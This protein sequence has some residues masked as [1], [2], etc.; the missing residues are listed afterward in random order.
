MNQQNTANRRKN[1]DGNANKQTAQILQK[2][3]EIY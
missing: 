1:A 2:E 3:E